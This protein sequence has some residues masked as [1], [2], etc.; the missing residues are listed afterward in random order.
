[1]FQFIFVQKEEI[2]KIVLDKNFMI[3]SNNFTY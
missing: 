1:M 3:N 2:E